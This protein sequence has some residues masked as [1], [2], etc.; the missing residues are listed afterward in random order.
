MD[1]EAPLEASPPTELAAGVAAAVESPSFE[2]PLPS[3]AFSPSEP[4]DAATFPPSSAAF[5]E[6]GEDVA[7]RSFLAQPDPL[8][9]IAGVA[10]AFLTGPPP[11]N[12]HSVGSAAWTPRRISN[13][14]PQ[15]AQ[16]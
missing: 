11:H 5:D 3:D 12:G 9:W 8:K 13:R 10:N 15:V 7:R 14:R 2:S 16:S 6:P 4:A 1:L